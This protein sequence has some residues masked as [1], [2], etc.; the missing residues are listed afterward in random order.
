MFGA[1]VEPES[2]RAFLGGFSKGSERPRRVAGARPCVKLYRMP[3]ARARL[4]AVV[5]VAS[6]FAS[7]TGFARVQFL[8][9][10]TG[11]VGSACCCAH[12][13]DGAEPAGAGVRPSD[14]CEAVAGKSA[15]RAVTEPPSGVQ[16]PEALS[17]V[18]LSFVV[19]QA[20]NVVV[21]PPRL[22]RSRGPPANGPPLYIKH[23]SLLG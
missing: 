16:V 14:C 17:S 18:L 3:R 6:L 21:E 11:L 7:A 2:E 22:V 10:M 23:C 13:E 1:R 9:R 19:P 20:P 12:H 5:L 15:E 4:F 8:C